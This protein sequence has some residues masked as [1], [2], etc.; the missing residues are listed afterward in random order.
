METPT[1]LPFVV[2]L[3]ARSPDDVIDAAVLEAFSSRQLPVARTLD[4]TRVR[5]SAPLL[6]PT[7]SP[8]LETSEDGTV[9]RLARGNGWMLRTVRHANGS[10]RLTALATSV[11]L[12][13][14]ILAAASR[15]AVAP[16]P[17]D[18]AC[19][20]FWHR[21]KYGAKRAERALPIERWTDIRSNYAG[22]TAATLDALM[23]TDPALLEGRLALLFGPPG[24][25][26]TTLIRSIADAWRSW[27][28]PEYVLDADHLLADPAYL[29]RVLL[30]DEHDDPD[31]HD[32][33]ARAKRWRL[34]VLEDCGEFLRADA[35]EATGQGLSRLLNLPDGLI[36]QGL[37]LLVLISTND[38]LARLHPAITRPGRCFAQI[39]VGPLPAVEAGRWLGRRDG[40]GPEGATLAVLYALRGARAAVV[41]AAAPAG[42]Y[43]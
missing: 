40:I 27:C 32:D 17:D 29:M 11:A 24:T 28:T 23:R 43:L 7:A 41:A 42:M 16:A 30:D 18:T 6:P 37:N 3:D 1:P 10:A 19:F 34:L 4:L 33:S 36:G 21:G 22:T 39:E 31:D 35:K 8:F 15:D 26:K 13:K 20:A 14:S 5:S 2:Q 38:E 25:G 9:T 12:A